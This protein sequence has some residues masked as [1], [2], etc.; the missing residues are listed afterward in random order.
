MVQSF[1]TSTAFTGG[2]GGGGLGGGTGG[3]GH[4]LHGG[5]V[6][7]VVASTSVASA[8]A[9]FVLVWCLHGLGRL[10]LGVAVSASGGGVPRWWPSCAAPFQCHGLHFGGGGLLGH[11]LH[12]GGVPRWWSW[13]RW[14][15]CASSMFRTW[16]P[17]SPLV[18]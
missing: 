10:L 12:G 14:P 8:S 11:G 18:Y 4:G 5:G 7:P 2:G 17:V 15:R 9:F 16:S 1:S 6:P 3:G 13:P